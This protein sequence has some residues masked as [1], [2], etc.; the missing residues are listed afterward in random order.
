AALARRAGPV[1]AALRAAGPAAA[2]NRK[3]GNPGEREVLTGSPGLGEVEMVWLRP[4]L[5]SP[6]PMISTGDRHRARPLTRP[7]TGITLRVSLARRRS[8]GRAGRYE[9][10]SSD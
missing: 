7:L 2:H 9:E 3:P 5:S 4:V 10:S 6:P 8:P 1:L